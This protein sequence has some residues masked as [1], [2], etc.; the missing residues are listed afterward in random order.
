MRWRNDRPAAGGPDQG[1]GG[2][3]RA[4]PTPSISAWCNGGVW[5]TTDCRTD[6]DPDFDDQPT[7]SI[8]SIAVAPSDPNIIYV[9]SGEGLQRPD[10]SIGDGMYK[11]TDAGK[12]WTHLGLRDA[13][14]DSRRSRSIPRIRTGCSSRCWVILTARMRNAASSVPPTAARRSR[15]C[16]YKDENT[17]GNDVDSTP[18]IRTS[19][20]QTLLG[21]ASGSVGKRRLERTRRRDVQVD[22]RRH[23]VEAL[24]KGLPARS[25]RAAIAGP[26][27]PSRRAIQSA[28]ARRGRGAADA[29]SVVLSVR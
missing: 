20:T 10:L 15:K 29:A 19:S 18:P 1:G 8:G 3:A 16:S 14:A 6:V 9:G 11:S 4:S 23:D 21:G 22:R 28:G 2:R 26:I 17:G 27:S 5:K 12:T 24:T 13:P 25:E 7:G